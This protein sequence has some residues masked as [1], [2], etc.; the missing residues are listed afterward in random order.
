MQMA[1]NFLYMDLHLSTIFS[2]HESFALNRH[3]LGQL[4]V[5]EILVDSWTT[6]RAFA[7]K[8]IVNH[9]KQLSFTSGVMESRT[10]ES[11]DANDV[12]SVLA[13]TMQT[14]DPLLYDRSRFFVTDV[15]VRNPCFS[16]FVRDQ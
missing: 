10:I 12:E 9:S 2:S 15:I 3:Q 11:T 14:G 6:I 5:V 1:S 4:L 16:F 8:F 13:S 7:Y